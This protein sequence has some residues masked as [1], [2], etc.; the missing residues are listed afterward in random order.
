MYENK[1]IK[2]RLEI[3]NISPLVIGNG[4][5]G[6]EG[7]QMQNGHAKIPATSL[8]GIFRNDLSK[9]KAY[10]SLYEAIYLEKQQGLEKTLKRNEKRRQSMMSLEDSFTKNKIDAEF[11][12]GKRTN[13]RIDPMTGAAQEKKL[14]D[15]FYIQPGQIFELEL[16]FRK[17]KQDN[18][19]A[20]SEEFKN[21]DDDNLFK[22]AEQAFDT[23]IEK[24]HLGDAVIGAGGN[25]GFGRFEVIKLSKTNYNFMNKNDLEKYINNESLP[26]ENY[27]PPKEKTYALNEFVVEMICPQGMIIKDKILTKDKRKWIDSFRENKNLGYRIPS[28]TLKGLVR[29]YCESLDENEELVNFIFG[30]EESKG[31]IKF[32][33]IDIKENQELRKHRISIDRFTGGA[34]KGAMVNEILVTWTKPVKWRIDFSEIDSERLEETKTIILKMI[35]ALSLGKLRIGSGSSVGYGR[36]EIT[37]INVF[38]SEDGR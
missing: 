20:K 29:G 2:Y 18:L 6:I 24:L 34:R 26:Y 11:H 17:V 33:D 35:R 37:K 21:I 16:E 25:K 19:S 30:S 1:I 13:I 14:F 27:V 12:I 7:I 22:Q 15:T 3:K 23:F 32:S 5:D 38:E 10:E 28:S 4:E 9:S 36:M 8:A 31:K